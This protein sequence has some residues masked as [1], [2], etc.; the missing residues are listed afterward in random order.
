MPSKSFFLIILISVVAKISM[1]YSRRLNCFK[2]GT[3]NIFKF[4]SIGNNIVQGDSTNVESYKQ[5][6]L[7]S[8]IL[9]DVLF[10]DPPYCILTRFKNSVHN[11]YIASD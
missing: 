6:G 3:E 5:A 8:I 7:S 11:S 10:T 9:A 4:S 2:K 1:L